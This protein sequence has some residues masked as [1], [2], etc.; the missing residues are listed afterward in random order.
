[1]K[2]REWL[3]HCLPCLGF[4]GPHSPQYSQTSN[5][6]ASSFWLTLH[7]TWDKTHNLYQTF[8]V[9]CV[10][11]LMPVLEWSVRMVCKV[12]L[13]GK[14]NSAWRNLLDL[15]PHFKRERVNTLSLKLHLL[16]SGFMPTV[17]NNGCK[18]SLNLYI[19]GRWKSVYQRLPSNVHT[20]LQFLVMYF[21]LSCKVHSLSG[22]NSVIQLLFAWSLFCHSVQNQAILWE[23]AMLYALWK[24]QSTCSVLCL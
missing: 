9:E 1:M 6:N 5:W 3:Q 20:S 19:Q 15:G 7:Q 12:H 21:F 24:F 10:W 13:E 18:K 22:P 17:P 2:T 16:P 8:S 4:Q 23:N 11:A 14:G